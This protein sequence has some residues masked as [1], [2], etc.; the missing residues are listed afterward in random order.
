[1]ELGET[2]PVWPGPG[3]NPLGCLLV[4]L[5][6]VGARAA[7][8]IQQMAISHPALRVLFHSR[9]PDATKDLPGTVEIPNTILREPSSRELLDAAWQN[10][11]GP[12]DSRATI[13]IVDDEAGLRRMIGTAL[14]SAGYRV[15]EAGDG[16]EAID[17]LG[18]TS[19]DLVLTDLIMPGQEGI[20]TIRELRRNFPEVK[21]IAISGAVLGGLLRM[22]QIL[23]AD[24]ALAKPVDFEELVTTVREVLSSVPGE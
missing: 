9:D 20:E 10:F 11:G 18:R 4:N 2:R 13:L 6:E 24:A 17:L 21:I 22:A 16:R 8:L 23:G 12:P 5:D 14:K 19:V 15:L 7:E 1:M 3:T